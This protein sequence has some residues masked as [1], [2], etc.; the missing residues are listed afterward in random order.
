MIAT[1]ERFVFRFRLAILLFLAA[2]T[3][4]MGNFASNLRMDAGFAKQLP[5]GHEYIE[6][7]FEYQDQLFGANRVMIALRARDGDIWTTKGLQKL[8]EATD[9]ISFLPGIDRR[10]VTSLWTLAPYQHSQKSDSPH[11]SIPTIPFVRRGSL[12]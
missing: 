1:L 7:F 12:A 2:L 3:L 6:T 5:K 8:S 10:T 4:V 11:L 9:A